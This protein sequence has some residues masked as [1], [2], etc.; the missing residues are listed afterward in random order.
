MI[1]ELSIY[2]FPKVKDFPTISIIVLTQDIK[3][4][5]IF[6]KVSICFSILDKVIPAYI[7]HWEQCNLAGRCLGRFSKFNA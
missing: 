3:T 1:G 4:G 7:A 2:G 5:G 6:F